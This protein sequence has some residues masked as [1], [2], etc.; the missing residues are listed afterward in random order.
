V[1]YRALTCLN[2]LGLVDDMLTITRNDLFPSAEDISSLSLHFSLPAPLPE[3]LRR[4][5]PSEVGTKERGRSVSLR[6]LAP[7]VVPRGKTRR[8]WTPLDLDNPEFIATL[9][10]RAKLKKDFVLHNKVGGA[11]VVDSGRQQ[12]VF[13]VPG[14]VCSFVCLAL[15]GKLRFLR[16]SGLKNL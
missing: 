15:F 8:V 9:R 1:G 11:L 2:W 6:P 16:V 4:D 5:V 14:E 12:S 13:M 7:N 3:P 10:Q